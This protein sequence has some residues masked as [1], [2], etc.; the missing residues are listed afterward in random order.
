[1]YAPDWGI[2]VIKYII[3]RFFLGGFFAYDSETYIY[4]DI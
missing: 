1:M 3:N 2:N 4:L